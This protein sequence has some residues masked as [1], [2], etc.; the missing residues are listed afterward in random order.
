MEICS[1]YALVQHAFSVRRFVVT[2]SRYQRLAKRCFVFIEI[3]AATVIFKADNG[4]CCDRGI[5]CH[6]V[7]RA[8]FSATGF[9]TDNGQPF[10]TFVAHHIKTPEQLIS[11]A[12]RKQCA[13]GFYVCSQLLLLSEQLMAYGKL[14]TVCPASQ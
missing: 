12:N 10:D 9:R 6:I 7:D 11:S 1:D 4:R 3:R 2:G 14:V 8:A 5:N 13:I